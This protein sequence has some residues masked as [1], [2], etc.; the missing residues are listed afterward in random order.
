MG[1]GLFSA[2][3]AKV[4][5]G[6]AWRFCAFSVTQNSLPENKTKTKETEV[7]D[8]EKPISDDAV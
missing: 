4:L 8:E 3:L 2:Q 6:E 7:R 1:K 5:G